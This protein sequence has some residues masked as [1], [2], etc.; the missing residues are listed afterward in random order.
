MNLH[1]R[2]F[3][4]D[5]LFY[6]HLLYW[7]LLLVALRLAPWRHLRGGRLHVFLGACVGVLLVWQIRAG[8]T[9]GLEVHL[10]GATFMTLMFGWQ[11]AAVGMSLTLAGATLN[12]VGD[13]PA[14]ALNGLIDVCVPV[15]LSYGLARLMERRLPSHFFIYLF[16][17]AF[18][19]GVLTIGVVGLLSSAAL[20][21]AGSVPP[22]QIR[23]YLAVYV[24]LL[25]PEGFTTGMLMTLAVVY[26]PEW[27]ISFNDRRYLDGH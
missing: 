9:A 23:D 15:W 24:L 6:S 5:W 26:R 2:L 1:S 20:I 27:V 11:L 10:L 3:D 13:W 4:A 19:G 18:F 22:A 12:G 14:F 21:V 17:A 25:F 7:P 16:V 8:L